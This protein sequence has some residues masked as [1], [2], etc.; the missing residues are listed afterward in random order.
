MNFLK[1]SIVAIDKG[2]NNYTWYNSLTN[3]TIFFVARLKSNT[4][5]RI[6]SRRP[7][8]LRRITYKDQETIDKSDG[9]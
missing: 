2:Y 6:I 7:I 4:K 1:G 8:Q 3:K 5:H 9:W